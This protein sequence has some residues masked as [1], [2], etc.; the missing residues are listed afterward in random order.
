MTSFKSINPKN[1][2][3]FKTY[4]S[5]TNHK[6]YEALER[7]YNSYKFMRNQG[8]DGVKERLQKLLKVKQIMGD[9]KARIAENITADMGKPIT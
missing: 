6:M 9:K 2:K 5:I 1:G 8:A 7:S 3:L 4:D